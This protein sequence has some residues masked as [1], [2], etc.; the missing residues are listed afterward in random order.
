MQ[1]IRSDSTT[2]AGVQLEVTG[3][4]AIGLDLTT[5]MNQALI[6]YVLVIVILSF[7]LMILMFRSLLVPLFATL[8]YLLS[9]GAALGALDYQV[10]LVSRIREGYADGLSP[11]EAIV[12]GITT[13]GPVL[14]AAALIMAFV[15]GGFASSTMTFGAETAFGLLVG[16]LADALL[17]RMVIMPALLSLVGGAAWWLPRWLD[18]IVPNLDTEGHSLD[19][20]HTT[21]V[22]VDDRILA[23]VS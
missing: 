11:R 22:A 23:G 21:P 3:E 13:S 19:T 14:V 8:G 10:F 20:P 15:F 5:V 18:R 1:D 4:T 12:S 7:L 16:V 9:L 17:V 6:Q 2:I